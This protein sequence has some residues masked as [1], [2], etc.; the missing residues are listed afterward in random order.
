VLFGLLLGP[1]IAVLGLVLHGYELSEIAP[2]W[3]ILTVGGT[4]F[5]LSFIGVA[6]GYYRT[7]REGERR[8]SPVLEVRSVDRTTS[9]ILDSQIAHYTKVNTICKNRNNGSATFYHYSGMIVR[10]TITLLFHNRYHV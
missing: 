10:D 4:I 1:F 2:K 6:I 8:T 9:E 3:V 5:G 7:V